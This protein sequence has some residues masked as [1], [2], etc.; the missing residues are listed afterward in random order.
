LLHTFPDPQLV[1]LA[2]L[3]VSAQTIVPLA[4]VVAPVLQGLVG[5]Q[6]IAFVH[7]PHVPL[8]QTLFV[9]QLVPLATFPVSTHADTPVT[10]DV[11][12]VLHTF[13]GWQLTPPVH[14]TQL[15]VLQTL[16]VPQ[17]VPLARLLP[18]SEQLID[19]EQTV[20]PA[21]QRFVGAQARPAVQATHTP[22]LQTM[23]VPHIVP[24]ATLP[25]SV[26]TGAPLVQTVAAVRQGL[27]LTVQLAPAVQAT[28]LPEALQ[29]L[30]VPQLVPAVT[31]VVLSLQTGVPV[32]QDSVPWWQG[33]VGTQDAP[34]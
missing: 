14:A 34:S 20:M 33:L 28:Q 9:P 19:G 22:V 4:H 29:T 23:F 5:G 7:D 6:L 3:P 24:L 25:V 2:T 30:F 8:L 31:A 11:A 12:P 15:P 21:W 18:V 16:F 1:P 17:V 26:Q 10:H 27:P 13:V 32:E